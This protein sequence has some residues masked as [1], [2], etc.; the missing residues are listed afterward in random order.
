MGRVLAI[1]ILPLATTWLWLASLPVPDVQPGGL[2]VGEALGGTQTE[3]FARVQAPRELHFPEDHGEHPAYRNEWWYLTG[4]LQGPDGRHFGF[5][6]TLFR[7]ALAPGPAP[8]D[9]AWRS[10]QVYMAHLGLS[11]TR[12]ARHRAVERFARG[13]SLGLAGVRLLPFRA[14]L[15]HW[16]LDGGH[17]DLFPLRLTAEEEDFGLELEFEALKP[18]VLQGDRG[19]SQKSA[20]PGNASHYYSYTRLAARGTVRTADNTVSVAGT[21]WMDREW[22]TSALAPEQS[23]WDWFALQFDDGRD[24]MIYRMRRHDG[25]H[26]PHSKGIL[27]AE[28]GGSRLLRDH[29]FRL[30]PLAWWTS[31]ATGDR[32]PVRWHVEVPGEALSLEVRAR[33]QA[34]EM[35]L[36][37]RY[38]EGAVTVHDRDRAGRPVGLGYLE[39]TRY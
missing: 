35:N 12:E 16:R 9:S 4:N 22:S 34:Q 6:F 38:W 10:H 32:Y 17:E 31:P 27:V 21:A 2:A 3:G 7:I 15:D 25:A 11:D 14:W 36:T 26:D 39:M 5:Q 13:G 24:L 23:G 37:V 1:L 28:D 8:G 30:T 29:E 20:E 33:L 18:L 19:L